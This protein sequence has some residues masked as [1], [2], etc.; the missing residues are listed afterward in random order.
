[1]KVSEHKTPVP[2]TVVT[3]LSVLRAVCSAHLLPVPTLEYGVKRQHERQK[4]VGE[5]FHR[6]SKHAQ[7]GHHIAQQN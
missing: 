2:L 6:E 7:I 3:V 4:Q 1:M 5:D